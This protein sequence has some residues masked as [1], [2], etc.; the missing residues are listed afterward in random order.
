[1]RRWGELEDRAL[2]W[3]LALILVGAGVTLLI[4]NR[5]QWF[6]GDDWDFLKDR[7]ARSATDLF[8]PHNEHWSTI[9][10]LIYRGIFS[11]VGI[12]SHVPYILVLI[13]LHLAVVFLVWKLIVSMG[14]NRYVAVGVAA[15]LSVFG[16]GSENLLWAFQIGFVGSI[17]LGLLQ[18]ILFDHEGQSTPRDAA[19]VGVGILNLMFS[20]MALPMIAAV[21]MFVAI[22][23]RLRDA[24][25][26]TSI[27]TLIFVGWYVLVGNRGLGEAYPSVDQALDNLPEYLWI[28]LTA[29]VEGLVGNG[30]FLFPIFIVGFIYCVGSNYKRFASAIAGVAGAITMFAILVFSRS[31]A[32]V[33]FAGTSRYLY[34]AAALMLPAIAVVL[35]RIIRAG[36]IG[37]VVVLAVL[38]LSGVRGV[39][40]L[41][42][43]AREQGSRE[44]QLKAQILQGVDLAQ[45]DDSLLS[46]EVEPTFNPRLN[47]QEL[48]PLKE[49][50]LLPSGG[51]DGVP[52]LL[53]AQASL[54]ISV[55][56]E[57]VLPIGEAAVLG[58]A[59]AAQVSEVLAC[60]TVQ[61][62]ES[63]PQIVLSF[64]VEASVELRPSSAGALEVFLRDQ[65]ADITV[66]ARTFDLEGGRA[67]FLNVG[68]SEVEPIVTL[69]A[70]GTTE[71]CGLDTGLA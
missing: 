38:V 67:Y 53:A 45:A 22:K 70:A 56:N 39:E 14:L 31:A 11:L 15:V 3:A 57:P 42:D 51:R 30:S 23:R 41:F 26:L 20:G 63:V 4:A 43:D 44:Q 37:G 40:L 1:M 66:G 47:T 62:L 50:G 33:E 16:A 9:P 52:A 25:L 54:N 71:I 46:L 65:E 19:G 29:T 35:D 27:P 64:P 69:P 49:Q 2:K 12:R 6:I 10:I 48:L 59:R 5:D 34:M 7:S 13:V 60:I 28:G 18:M 21:G 17:A 58:Y 61:P 8:T 55:T 36:A 32:G 24:V 68:V